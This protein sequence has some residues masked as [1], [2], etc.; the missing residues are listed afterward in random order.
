MTTASNTDIGHSVHPQSSQVTVPAHGEVDVDVELSVPAATAGDS[1]AFTDVS[2]LITFTPA[3]GNNNGV[4]LN[5]PYYFVPQ[6]ISR[7]ETRLDGRALRKAGSAAATVTNRGGAI[8]GAA[9]WYAWGLADKRD[10]GLHSNDLRAVGVQTFPLDGVLAF[11]ISTNHRWSNAAANE[12]DIYVD[13]DGDGTPDYDVVGV[14]FGAITAGSFDGRMAVA[15]F[16]L[17]AGGGSIQFL[18]DAPKDSS[19]LVLPVLFSQLCT[20]GNPCLSSTANP[21]FNYWVQSFRPDGRHLGHDR[22]D[23]RLQPVHPVDQ[24][25]HVRR[26]GPGR[27]RGRDRLDR[28]SRMGEDPGAG[29]D[30]RQP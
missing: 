17:H 22:R 4:S 13:V 5:V 21:R 2:G 25:R 1:S 27:Q 23:R 20:T 16:P 3:A 15:V 24:H 6:A 14:D 7:I 19:T 28:R 9:D 11:A 10:H 29:P 26:G 12:F 18:A 30:D 8:A